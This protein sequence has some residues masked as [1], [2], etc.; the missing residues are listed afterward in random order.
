MEA[1]KS[2]QMATKWPQVGPKWVRLTPKNAPDL[3]TKV[4]QQWCSSYTIAATPKLPPESI[5]YPLTGTKMATK[6][7]QMDPEGGQQ[8]HKLDLLSHSYS[9]QQAHRL[10]L[11]RLQPHYTEKWQK[12]KTNIKMHPEARVVAPAAHVVSPPMFWR[13]WL[14]QPTIGKTHSARL[15]D[16]FLFSS[17][18]VESGSH[19]D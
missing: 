6:L 2:C 15:L 16:L 1:G 12:R 19:R 11:L 7:R 14:F 13:L 18:S 8:T 5:V 3:A 9:P 17:V 10:D 4:Q